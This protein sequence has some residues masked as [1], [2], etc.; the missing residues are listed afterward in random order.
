MKQEILIKC[1]TKLFIALESILD[2][3][4]EL[5][6]LSEENYQ[7]LKKQILEQ[8]F[9]APIF[10]WKNDGKWYC[11]DGTQRRI[12]LKRMKSEGYSVPDLPCVEVIAK[13]KIEAKKKLLSYVSQFGKVSPTGLFQYMAEADIGIENMDDFEI[14]E[15]DMDAFRE[16]FFGIGDEAVSESESKEE[17][18]K[19]L[20][21]CPNCGHL[22]S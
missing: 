22:I 7:K 5:K 2:F 9:C 19:E 16:E 11:L 12:T 1:D 17:K 21:K 18:E 4:G 6:V 10:V 14:P 3:Q 20:T 8:G 13:T 15:V